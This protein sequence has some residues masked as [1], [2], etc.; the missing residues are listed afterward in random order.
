M[1]GTRQYRSFPCQFCASEVQQKAN[2]INGHRA[3]NGT[4]LIF[5]SSPRA[6]SYTA[7]RKP[8]RNL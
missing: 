2:W 8:T 7:S 4:P 5:S 1:R 3:L 6:S